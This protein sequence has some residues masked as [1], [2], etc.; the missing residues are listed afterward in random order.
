MLRCNTPKAMYLPNAKETLASWRKLKPGA[1]QL[2]VPEELIFDVANQLA[3]D[4]LDMVC[5]L[6]VQFDGCLRPS[7]A[8]GLTWD[9]VVEPAGR[10]YASWGLILFPSEMQ[11]RSKTGK[12][13][14]SILLGDIPERKWMGQV[15]QRLFNSTADRLFPGISQAQ[16]ERALRK[17][18]DQLGNLA[19][20]ALPRIVRHSS[21][22][23]DACHQR[24]DLRAIQKR[25]RWAA[26]SSV[27]R[28]EKHM[29]FFNVPGSLS[30]LIVSHL[31]RRPSNDWYR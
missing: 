22:S 27:N 1:M 2:P 10:R 31:S 30:L 29:A 6:L 15:I 16:Y 17:A 3:I 25:G 20:V 19:P 13:D 5:L 4:Q 14:D 26:K 8:I 9:N 12:A 11:A 21:A 28:Y 7:E 24:R 23:N 18:C